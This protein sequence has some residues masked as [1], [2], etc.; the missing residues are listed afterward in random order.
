MPKKYKF[1]FAIIAL[2]FVEGILFFLASNAK[3]DV[4]A[5]RG[6]ISGFRC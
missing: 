3:T 6:D 5:D 2:D 1:L 4:G